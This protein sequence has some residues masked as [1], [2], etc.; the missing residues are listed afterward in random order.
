MHP[1]ARV[2]H[3]F[4]R[5]PWLYWAVV[6]AIA[7]GAA[8]LTADAVAGVDEARRSWGATREVIVATVDIAPGQ[9]LAGRT[10]PRPRPGPTV[11]GRA[12]VTA[13]SGAVARQ[14]VVA[15]EV[16]VDTD[17]AAGAAPVSL[18]PEGWR[19]VAVAE[20]VPSGSAI[21]DR[22]AAAS[23]GVVLATDGVVV[24]QSGDAVIVAVPAAEA[25][26]V[27]AAGAA[28]ELT[29]LLVP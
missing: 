15:G 24:G 25:A 13:A 20:A 2:R 23:G 10:A 26:Q 21:G 28:G 5:R 14:H 29:L 6:V 11:P 17:V 7:S 27:A 22:V 16:L 8:L 19:G 9:P 12:L 3:V 18:I 4:A 1:V